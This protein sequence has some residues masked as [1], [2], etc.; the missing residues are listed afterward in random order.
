MNIIPFF[1]MTFSPVNVNDIPDAG[2]KFVFD[3][4]NIKINDKITEIIDYMIEKIAKN[5]A[6]FFLI[7]GLTPT[8]N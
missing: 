5:F 3:L 6:L 7:S 1:K 4:T 8:K 2:I